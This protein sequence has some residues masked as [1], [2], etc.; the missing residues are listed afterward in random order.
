MKQKIKN[1]ILGLIIG[2][3]LGVPF[4]FQP[5]EWRK[6]YPVKD[7]MGHGVHDQPLGTWSDDTSMTLCTI[8]NFIDGYNQH[9]LA[10]SFANWLVK[11]EWTPHGRVF[12][13]GMTTSRAIHNFIDS[14]QISGGTDEHSNGNGSLMRILPLAY[15]LHDTPFYNRVQ[16]VNEVSAITHGHDTSQKACIFYVEMAINLLNGLSPLDAYK[17]TSEDFKLYYD[18]IA[19][20][21]I[22]QGDIHTLPESNIKSTGY[23]VSTLEASIWCL[24][25]GKDF[26]D[27]VLKA[28][29][30]GDDTDTTGAVAGGL[31][32]IV[33]TPPKKWVSKIV[34]L[35]EI[36]S[37]L[38]KM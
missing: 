34:K 7:M 12:D 9:G 3:A 5:R 1:G 29:N 24:I 6:K 26:A 20:K 17:K 8:Q 21:R 35:D 15:F 25:N 22:L 14:K 30:L 2:D 31:A 16:I 33:Y 27:V 13:V 32:G 10:Q 19:L 18:T 11:N 36:N 37:L 28:V 38:D 23:V 4:E